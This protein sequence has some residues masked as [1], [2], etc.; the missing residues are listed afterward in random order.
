MQPLIHLSHQVVFNQKLMTNIDSAHCAY[1]CE[2]PNETLP[3]IA[4]GT[5]C[6]GP[7]GPYGC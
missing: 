4:G 1:L 3:A 7:D 5:C 2:E 6:L